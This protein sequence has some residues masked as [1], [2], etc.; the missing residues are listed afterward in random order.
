MG[1]TTGAD[2]P[3]HFEPVL[4]LTL[5]RRLLGQSQGRIEARSVS[6]A[7]EAIARAANPTEPDR[8]WVAQLVM[9]PGARQ[10]LYIGAVL[11]CYSGRCLA[12]RHSASPASPVLQSI[13]VAAEARRHRLSEFDRSPLGRPVVLTLS[14]RAADV[15][16]VPEAA[17]PLNSLAERVAA[18]FS[19]WLR[20]DLTLSGSWRTRGEAIQAVGGWV[21]RYYNPEISTLAITLRPSQPSSF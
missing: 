11:D 15:C 10:P 13:Q 16:F 2:S 4:S 20:A 6:T 9:V 1:P 21:D 3:H 8:L 19:D 5:V 18:R 14:R 17:A 12:W 7:P